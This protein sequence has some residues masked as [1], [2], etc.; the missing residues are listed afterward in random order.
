MLRVVCSRRLWCAVQYQLRYCP[1][2]AKKPVANKATSENDLG[3][4]R[5]NGNNNGTNDNN[6]KPSTEQQER[7]QPP[8]K[9][10]KPDPFANPSP[11][12]LITT[13]PTHTLVL[14]KFPIINNHFILATNEWKAQDF[15]L[16]LDDL[17]TAFWC[18]KNWGDTDD[19][20]SGGSGGD[21]SNGNGNGGDGGKGDNSNEKP[22]LFA[23]YNS[24]TDS[25]ASQPHR[26]VQFLPIEEMR[27]VSGDV[28]GDGSGSGTTAGDWVPVID[29]ATS[30][31][32]STLQHI[33]NLPFKHAALPIPPN[34]SPE[35]LHEMYLRLYRVAVSMTRDG[36]GAGDGNATDI[37]TTGQ[38]EISYN[39]AMTTDTML[40]CPRRS[41]TAGFRVPAS[42][43]VGVAQGED[44]REGEG[45]GVVSVN[46]T[47]LAGTLMVKAETEWGL[48]R[49]WPECLRGVL[50]SVGY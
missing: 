17:R 44:G 42:G 16:D 20:G 7:E 41:E 33:P 38:A 49:R 40:I 23:F 22:R 12:L 24:G 27:G 19:S 26:H 28:F 1:T 14:N 15:L 50:G 29:K 35:T 18:L 21:N 13:T 43:S 4:G 6:T 48:L 5:S 25:G 10:Q 37:P 39:L 2:L 46:G 32:T 36:D 11:D 9:L 47:V 34:P 30:T 3:V 8:P 31:S 45:E